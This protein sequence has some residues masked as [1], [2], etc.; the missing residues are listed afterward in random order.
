MNT[1]ILYDVQE[2]GTKTSHAVG[3]ERAELVSES[4]L[5]LLK[6]SINVITTLGDS[7]YPEVPQLYRDLKDAIRK[8][9]NNP[10]WNEWED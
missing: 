4:T 5:Y 2:D 3:E 8:E 6:R 9:E 1:V 7:D 10:D